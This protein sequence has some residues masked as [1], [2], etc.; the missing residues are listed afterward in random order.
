MR[1]DYAKGGFIGSPGERDGHRAMLDP[2]YA[3][4]P[5]HVQTLMVRDLLGMD[6]RAPVTVSSTPSSCATPERY[7]RSG[8]GASDEEVITEQAG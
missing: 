8:Q 3:I 7:L 2:G 4:F 1:G 6:E 5:R